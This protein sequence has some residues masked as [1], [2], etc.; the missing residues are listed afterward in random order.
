MVDG[1]LCRWVQ[2]LFRLFLFAGLLSLQDIRLKLIKQLAADQFLLWAIAAQ[3]L[4]FFHSQIVA[5][6]ML[7]GQILE[8]LAANAAS[9]FL[10]RNGFFRLHHKIAASVFFLGSAGL[11]IVFLLLNLLLTKQR[12]G[13]RLG[14]HARELVIGLYKSSL[15]ECKLL[16]KKRNRLF[17]VSIHNELKKFG[18][19][20]HHINSCKT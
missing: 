16:N 12:F 15:H 1:P 5:L 8:G 19:A 11:G 6:N 9:D 17:G 3:L 14:I 20:D 13:E 7:G 4:I 2:V 10:F 18:I